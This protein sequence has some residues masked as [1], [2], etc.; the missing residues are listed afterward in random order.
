MEVEGATGP[1]Q[2][3]AGEGVRR[4]RPPSSRSKRQE[5]DGGIRHGSKVRVETEVINELVTRK[6]QKV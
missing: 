2:D 5:D 1:D 6:K 4:G 3:E